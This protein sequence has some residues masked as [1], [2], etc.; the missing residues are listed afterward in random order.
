[1]PL[2]TRSLTAA[3]A[4][5]L[6]GSALAACSGAAS[7]SGVAPTAQSA[8]TQAAPTTAALATQAAPT[9]QAAAT[10]GAAVAATGAPTAQA[11]ATQ[12]AP[13]AQALATQV[14]PTAQALAT[15]AA[16]TAQVLATQM[17]PTAQA[18]ATQAGPTLQAL[19]TQAAPI[20]ATAVANPPV[21]IL[22]AQ[23]T[24]SEATISLQNTSASSLDLSGWTL[25]VGSASVQLPSGLSVPAGQAV[26]LHT[27]SGTSTASD[28][29]LGSLGSSIAAQVKPGAQVV[30][31]NPGS[32]ASTAFTI[33]SA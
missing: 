19:A 7:P 10:T 33:P 25:R 16:P 24:S 13:T 2:N 11:L 12:A 8:A 21:R 27:G 30:L 32:G 22:G 23:S 1:M 26:V 18:L 3:L 14:A 31:Q 4:A 5:T 6:V 15:Q 17:A 9:L 28:V 20:A 29:Y